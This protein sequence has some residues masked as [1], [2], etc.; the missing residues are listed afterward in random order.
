MGDEQLALAALCAG[1]A[2]DQVSGSAGCLHV[3][4]LGLET[5]AHEFGLDHAPHRFDA[6]EVHRPAV[7]I[8]DALEETGG[9]SLLGIDGS[10]HDL[11]GG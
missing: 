6:G 8:D 1:V 7:L 9:A 5:E 3:D 4:P 10:K 11:L 2:R